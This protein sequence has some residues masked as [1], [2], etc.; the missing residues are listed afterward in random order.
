MGSLDDHENKISDLMSFIPSDSDS[1]QD[2]LGQIQGATERE[3]ATREISDFMKPKGAAWGK[4]HS[5]FLNKSSRNT[6]FQVR[7]LE[8]SSINLLLVPP[9]KGSAK[10]RTL[11][12]RTGE[13]TAYKT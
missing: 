2:G 8:S 9:Q 1:S 11:S 12:R 4:I 13:H 7:S 5:V 3:Q 6:L 10:T